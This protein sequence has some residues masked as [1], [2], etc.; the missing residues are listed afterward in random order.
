MG[1]KG[2]AGG[3][4]PRG[5]GRD[6]KERGRWLP[7]SQEGCARGSRGMKVGTAEMFV[8]F[9]TPRQVCCWYYIFE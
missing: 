5:R 4:G 6:W 9:N 2:G 1:P 3:V 8:S 7:G